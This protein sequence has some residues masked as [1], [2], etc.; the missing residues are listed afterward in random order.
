MEQDGSYVRS[1]PTCWE[2]VEF[3]ADY[4]SGDLPAERRAAFDAHLAQ[5]ASCVNYSKTYLEALR[6]ARM[7]IGCPDEP[8]STGVPEELVQAVLQARGETW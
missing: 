1:G 5:C 6:V 8:L 3:L 7:A 4:L 2:F